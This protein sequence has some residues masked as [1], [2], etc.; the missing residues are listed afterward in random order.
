MP[1]WPSVR[2]GTTTTQ[3]I[4]LIFHP[5]YLPTTTTS[6]QQG[7]LHSQLFNRV[8]LRGISPCC[9]CWSRNPLVLANHGWWCCFVARDETTTTSRP[10]KKT[11]GLLNTGLF[12]WS[13]TAPTAVTFSSSYGKATFNLS[14]S[15]TLRHNNNNHNIGAD[16]A[17]KETFWGVCMCVLCVVYLCDHGSRRAAHTKFDRVAPSLSLLTFG[18]LVFTIGQS[19]ESTKNL[20]DFLV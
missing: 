13:D 9:C 7:C 10:C 6:L 12:W 17:K 4:P 3:T 2:S 20:G 16:P 15:H 19:G 14:F 18:S 1:V 11:K 5:Y 8:L